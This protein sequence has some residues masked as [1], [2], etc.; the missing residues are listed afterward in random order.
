MIVKSID[1]GRT[2][3]GDEPTAAN[4]AGCVRQEGAALGKPTAS[5]GNPCIV[6]IHVVDKE[7]S[8][9][10]RLSSGRPSC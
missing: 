4:Q 5:F 7:D 8:L 9:R 10:R 3:F 2:F 6:P 1:G